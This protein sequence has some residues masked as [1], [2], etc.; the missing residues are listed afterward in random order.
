MMAKKKAAPE[1]ENDARGW[2]LTCIA[3][4]PELA[5]VAQRNYHARGY[6]ARVVKKS[7]GALC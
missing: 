7:G 6:E 1:P 2:Y 5:D 4:S 3:L